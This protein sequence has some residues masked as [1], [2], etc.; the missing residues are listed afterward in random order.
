M[1]AFLIYVFVTSITPGPSNIFIMNS[2]KK[3]GLLG[4]KKFIL[5]I[6]A[7]FLFLA[8]L[9][10]ICLYLFDEYIEAVEQT[11]KIFGFIYLL[12]LSYKTFTAS[13]NDE[14]GDVF[15]TFKAGFLLQ[16]LNMKTLLFYITLLGVFIIPNSNYKPFVYMVLTIII[17]WTCLI[18]WGVLG[19]YLKRY[20]NK[21]HY[22]FNTVMSL[23][24]L[25]SAFS[26]FY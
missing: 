11:L 21:Y 26:I 3:H 10:S 17:G 23:L 25:Y 18:V 16:I 2:T 7:V 6:L 12:Y 22:I 14:I 1:S 20:L 19:H 24:I 4:A 5:G 15:S 13:K 9:A 8:I